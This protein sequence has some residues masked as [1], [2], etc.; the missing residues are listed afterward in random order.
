MNDVTR[1]FWDGCCANVLT[2]MRCTLSPGHWGD[3]IGHS[4]SPGLV[5]NKN[6]ELARWPNTAESARFR[7]ICKEAYAADEA[8]N[9][10]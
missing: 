6:S 4:V 9:S 10:R 5:I 7:D 1:N 2:G 8:A 3:H